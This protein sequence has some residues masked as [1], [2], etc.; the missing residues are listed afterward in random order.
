MVTSI[1]VSEENHS[2]LSKI[3]LKNKSLKSMDDVISHII[4]YIPIHE[5]EI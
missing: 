1:Q 2:K 5:F 4:K 3:K